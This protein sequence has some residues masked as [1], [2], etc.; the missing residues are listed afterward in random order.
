M[1]NT[2]SLLGEKS[3]KFKHETFVRVKKD[4]GEMDIA[5]KEGLAAWDDRMVKTCGQIGLV[6]R[7]YGAG[8]TEVLLLDNT[9]VLGIDNWHYRNEWLDSVSDEIACDQLTEKQRMLFD[10]KINQEYC[11]R[12][13]AY[14]YQYAN[15]RCIS[16]LGARGTLIRVTDVDPRTDALSYEQSE[17]QFDSSMTHTL[18]QVGVVISGLE[19]RR[20][21]ATMVAMPFPVG[22]VYA[23]ENDNITVINDPLSMTDKER[24]RAD[25]MK[26]IVVKTLTV[27]PPATEEGRRTY[28][29]R[30]IAQE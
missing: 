23:F 17:I 8:N 27:P 16:R 3:T 10:E 21:S 6:T 4:L 18:G 7:G 29:F 15:Q 12:I 5:E 19:T 20:G 30:R 2:T 24:R 13:I 28:D 11:L 25:E 22:N 9:R 1:G 14:H 26:T